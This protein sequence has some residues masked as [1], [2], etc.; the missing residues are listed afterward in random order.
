MKVIKGFLGAGL[1]GLF[2]WNYHK[3]GFKTQFIKTMFSEGLF[4]SSK[5]IMRAIALFIKAYIKTISLQAYLST[6]N[7]LY[8]IIPHQ[9]SSKNFH[10]F[11]LYLYMLRKF[12]E[13]LRDD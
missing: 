8:V 13:Q 11:Y 12:G 5:T 4:N 6:E 7:K 9:R 2:Y 10:Q 1:E 3:K